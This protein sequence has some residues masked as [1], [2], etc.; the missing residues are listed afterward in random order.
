[1]MKLLFTG[2]CQ[3]SGLAVF[4]RRAR[5]DWE[6]H[7]LPHLA[8]FYSE[9]TEEQIAA[10]HAWADLVFYHE[11]HDHP[12]DYPTKQPKIP[13]SV[14]YQSAPFMAQF[15]QA[16]WD[17]VQYDEEKQA[18][19][20]NRDLYIDYLVR[21]YDFD[22]ERRWNDC[23]EKMKKKEE[24]EDVPSA[25]RMS[26]Y[27]NIWGK[28]R[29]CQL[30]C[31]HPTSYVFWEWTFNILVFLNEKV[32]PMWN[33]WQEVER[34]PNLAGLPCEESATTGARKHLNLSWGGR[35]EDDESGREIARR[36][37]K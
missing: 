1:M 2:N 10:E 28:A 12:Q 19:W 9:F 32:E 21:D 16:M 34:F 25:L 31:N 8:T 27:M 29:Q 35:P 7:D 4:M 17:A 11:K 20:K 33:L 6:I 14:W 37:L 36:M 5:P 18:F 23:W 24:D 30:T 26:E 3:S 15:D 22:Y 13:M